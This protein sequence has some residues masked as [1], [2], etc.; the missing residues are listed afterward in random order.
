MT[1][2]IC[3]EGVRNFYATLCCCFTAALM[4][5]DEC[6]PDLIT[7]P[8]RVES[9]VTPRP[10]VPLH[11]AC[12]RLTRNRVD[13]WLPELE[14]LTQMLK[15]LCDMASTLGQTEVARWL[16]DVSTMVA[17]DTMLIRNGYTQPTEDTR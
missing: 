13:V 2:L 12:Q 16:L 14:A 1:Q 10:P 5:D 11:I 6:H 3:T 9:W 17:D 15:Q 8:L 7:T 4:S